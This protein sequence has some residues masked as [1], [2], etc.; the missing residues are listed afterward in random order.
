M[1]T[2]RIVC[3]ANSRREGGR[4]VAGRELLGS[5]TLGEWIRPISSQETHAVPRRERLC[6]GRDP[7]VLDI[8][9]VRLLGHYPASPQVENWLIDTSRSW[10][11]A[12]SFPLAQL[13]RFIDTSGPL[14]IDGYSSASGA[15]NQV[16]TS[17]AYELADSLRLVKV[18]P[19]ELIV[20]EPWNKR[21]VEAT[22]TYSQCQYRLR[23]TD[24]V[25]EERYL[26]M[27][28]GGYVLDDAYL[29]V[30]LGEPYEGYFYKL[31]AAVILESEH[32]I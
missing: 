11:R 21:R 28:D 4:C 18:S 7:R 32:G 24:P 5:R 23:V 6:Q 31:V 20:H 9:D 12:G 30:S 15:N 17:R 8:I 26:N 1:P 13:D 27:E 19:V 3:L 2:K 10:S 22:F 29:T 16:P 14:W 25:I